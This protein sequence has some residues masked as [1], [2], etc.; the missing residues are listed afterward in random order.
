MLPRVGAVVK[1]CF[2]SSVRFKHKYQAGRQEQKNMPPI[3]ARECQHWNKDKRGENELNPDIHFSSGASCLSVV[4][5]RQCIS[6]GVS[7][8]QMLPQCGQ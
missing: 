2:V 1:G 3:K 7:T 8:K 6:V 5:P 4:S